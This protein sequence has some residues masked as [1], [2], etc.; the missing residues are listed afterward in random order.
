MEFI[1]VV[2]VVKRDIEKPTHASSLINTSR[3]LIIRSHTNHF[4]NNFSQ[5]WIFGWLLLGPLF[6][7]SAVTGFP[8]LTFTF[9]SIDCTFILWSWTLIFK[10]DLW[11]WAIDQSKTSFQIS[12]SKV[13]SQNL[14]V[15]TY[16]HTK[17]LIAVTTHLYTATGSGNT[18]MLIL[19]QVVYSIPRKN[20]IKYITN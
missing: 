16:K 4:S 12:M 2:L 18:M 17:H 3:P 8:N 1:I 9:Q 20:D 6:S 19:F 15:W 14:I 7:Y 10:H 5:T 11:T 13:T